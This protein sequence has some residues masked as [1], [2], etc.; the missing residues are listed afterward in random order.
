MSEDYISAIR[1]KFNY[2]EDKFA[3]SCDVENI[4]HVLN[5]EYKTIAGKFIEKYDIDNPSAAYGSIVPQF[6]LFSSD[7]KYSIEKFFFLKKN[8]MNLRKFDVEEGLKD[9]HIT[10]YENYKN[11]V[12]FFEYISGDPCF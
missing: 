2:L 10:L 12:E 7:D 8:P 5:D 3:E 6:K 9:N 11:T 1:N 4:K